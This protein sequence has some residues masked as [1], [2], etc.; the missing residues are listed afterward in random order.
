[1][2]QLFVRKVTAASLAGALLLPASLVGAESTLNSDTAGIQSLEQ[3]TLQP[4]GLDNIL[5]QSK[6][7]VSFR[8]TSVHDPSILKVKDTF[9]I[10]G[11][12]LAAAKSKDLM[13]WDTIATGVA[14]GNALIPNVKEELKEALDWAQTDTLWAADVIQLADGKFYMYYNACKGD[15]PRSA[16][17]LAVLIKLRTL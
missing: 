1:M 8:E 2:K 9:Y 14:N 4:Q 16:M 5:S 15:S 3:T 12:H 7:A 11:S 6:K 13:N 10:F 17:G